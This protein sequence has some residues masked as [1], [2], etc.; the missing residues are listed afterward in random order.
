FRKS[1]IPRLTTRS[2]ADRPSPCPMLIVQKYGGTSVGTVERMREV[3]RRCIAT[4]KQGHDVV[5]IVS[6]MAGETNRLLALAKQVH[7]ELPT[8][9]ERELDVIAATGEQVSVGLVSLA[10]AREGGRAQSFLGSQVRVVTD[11]S[12]TRARIK[13]IDGRL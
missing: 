1:T 7:P 6:A 2:V 5:V 3:A 13:S 8:E 11:S 12:F 9:Y 10:I 4:Q